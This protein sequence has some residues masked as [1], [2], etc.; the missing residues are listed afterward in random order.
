[1]SLQ[2]DPPPADPAPA[3]TRKSLAKAREHIRPNAK[4]LMISDFNAA[5]EILRSSK[6][7][8]AGAGVDLLDITKTDEVGLFYLDGEPHRRK[9]AV[10]SRF[11]TLKAIETRYRDVMERATDMLLARLAA[12]GR[13]RLD[14][15]GFQL[16]VAVA[17]EVIGLDHSDVEGLAARVGATQGASDGRL[18]VKDAA[19]AAIR[20]FFEVDVKPAIEARRRERREDVISH[21]L[22]EGWS[23]RAILT[24]VIAYSVAG[25]ATTREF[26]SMTAWYLLERPD[27]LERFRKGTEDEQFALLEEVLR[28]E[29]IVGILTRRAAEDIDSPLCG[30]IP[31]GTRIAIDLRATNMDESATGPCPHLIDPDRA[32]TTPDRSG[33]MSFGDGPHRCPGAQ[34]S[35]HEARVF[36]QKLFELPGLRLERAPRV[37]WY[38]PISGYELHEAVVVCDRTAED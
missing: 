24:E 22:D 1:L 4:T 7:R 18:P 33:F 26:I 8:Q 38:R 14:E 3:D 9:R 10:I 2:S 29:P 31:E 20:T 30:H 17:S 16:A 34:L 37:E 27:L 35:F 13:G 21:L 36:F 6:V 12:A 28:L 25:M 5:R 15:V 19:D 32:K 11:F 23:D